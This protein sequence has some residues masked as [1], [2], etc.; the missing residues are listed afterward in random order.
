MA[1]SPLILLLLL[2]IPLAPSASTSGVDRCDG[3]R[4]AFLARGIHFEERVPKEPVDGKKGMKKTH[5]GIDA[6]KTTIYGT[7]YFCLENVL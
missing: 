1:A 6:Q 5:E 3:V 7:A 2:L 4:N